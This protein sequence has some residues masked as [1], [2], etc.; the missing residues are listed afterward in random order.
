MHS[1][2]H[3]A[4]HSTLADLAPA[5][6][7]RNGN[8]DT[9]QEMPSAFNAAS[10][11]SLMN[12]LSLH[13]APS[14]TGTIASTEKYPPS[15]AQTSFM[16]SIEFF[17]IC[18]ADNQ[19]RARHARTFEP[20]GPEIGDSCH[21]MLGAVRLHFCTHQSTRQK[22]GSTIKPGRRSYMIG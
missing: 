13:A 18:T 3:A 2:V 16:Q 22:R 15:L 17:R 11:G 20:Q 6:A 4:L 10:A 21:I 9:P 12:F 1:I 19:G 5:D 8:A 14:S 7:A